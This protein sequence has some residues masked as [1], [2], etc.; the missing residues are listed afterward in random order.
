VGLQQTNLLRDIFG[1]LPFREVPIDPAWLAWNAC[2]VEKLAASIYEGRAFEQV[3]ILGDALEEAGCGNQEMLTHCRQQGQ[4]H[5]RGCW[6][7]D[8]LLQKG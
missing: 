6:L 5:V 8:L 4:P 1:P 3:P 7:L 2:V